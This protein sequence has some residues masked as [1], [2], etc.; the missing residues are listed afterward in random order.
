MTTVYEG[1]LLEMV[2]TWRGEPPEI[3][4]ALFGDLITQITKES[5]R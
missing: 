4:E 2:D 3:F 1:Q 5:D